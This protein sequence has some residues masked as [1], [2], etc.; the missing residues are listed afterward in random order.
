MYCVHCVCKV[1]FFVL[2]FKTI[3]S[4]LNLNFNNETVHK[5]TLTSFKSFQFNVPHRN[6]K[7]KNGQFGREKMLKGKNCIKSPQSD[8]QIKHI[9]AN[10]FSK[11]SLISKRSSIFSERA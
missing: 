3:V 5:S 7:R 4:V 1:C 6:K 11:R 10:V 8:L 2:A 9:C